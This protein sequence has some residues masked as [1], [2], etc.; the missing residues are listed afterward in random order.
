[1]LVWAVG[2]RALAAPTLRVVAEL[3][4]CGHLSNLPWPLLVAV[5]AAFAALGNVAAV[6]GVLG[7]VRELRVCVHEC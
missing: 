6:E 5:G 3:P 7:L 1:M 2:Q 4:R